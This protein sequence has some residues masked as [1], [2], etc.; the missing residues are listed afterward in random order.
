MSM[1]AHLNQEVKVTKVV[2][3]TGG[4]VA[5]HYLLSVDLSSHRDVLSNGQT[6]NIL[7]MRQSKS[8]TAQSDVT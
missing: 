4:C 1:M 6:K 3:A 8:V 7:R 5:T 2:I